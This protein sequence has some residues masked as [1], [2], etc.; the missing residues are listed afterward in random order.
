MEDVRLLKSP[1]PRL[2]MD[3]PNAKS[4]VKFQSINFTVKEHQRFKD[5]FWQIMTGELSDNGVFKPTPGLRRVCK[6][7]NIKIIHHDNAVWV[8]A[9]GVQKSEMIVLLKVKHFLHSYVTPKT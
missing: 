1:S 7:F 3:G 8:K 4:K 5:F 6:I 9:D 2:I